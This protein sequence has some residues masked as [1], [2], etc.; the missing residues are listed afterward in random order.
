MISYLIISYLINKMAFYPDK[1]DVLPLPENSS[2][3]FITAKDRTKLLGLFMENKISDKIVIY[4]H[5]NAG[6]IYHRIPD[7]EKIRNMG[8]NVF[9]LSYRGYAKSEGKPSEKGI[10]EDGDAAFDYVLNAL[11]F[12]LENVFIIGRSIGS[13]VA[14][15]TAQNKK[16]KGLI[17]IT[18]LTNAK[19]IAKTIGFGMFS[20]F[21]KDVFDN[22]SK[23]KNIIAPLLVIHGTNDDV[24]PYKMGLEIYESANKP[25]QFVEIKNAFH[26][27]LSIDHSREYFQAIK[28]FLHGLLF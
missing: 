15:N 6:N 13:T 20:S 24:I 21:M 28:R 22:K 11:G 26:N 1:Y 4:F 16:I 14:V 17:L 10:Y 27:N 12:K 19:D 7:L 2:E 9:G 23:M 3:V 5:G 8:F 18:P 25:K